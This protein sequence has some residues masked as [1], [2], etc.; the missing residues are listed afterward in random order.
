MTVRLPAEWEP[1]DAVLLAW[2][3]EETDW[4]SVLPLVEPVFLQLAATISRYEQVLIVTTDPVSLS[5]KLATFGATMSAITLVQVA[6]DDTWCRDFGPITVLDDSAPR[7]Q[8]FV[9]NGWGNKFFAEQDNAVTGH[10]QQQNTFS[11]PVDD[12]SLV[13]E[14][15]SIESDGCGTLLTTSQCL[16][17]SNRNPDYSKEQIEGELQDTLGCRR[18]LWLHHGHLLGDDTDAHIDTLA[19]LAPNDTILYV[20]CDDRED[21]H[22]P[23]LSRMAEELAAFRTDAG[24]PYRL[25]PLPWPAALF[26]AEGHR[27]PATYANFLIIN[28][29]V[30]VPTY[31]DPQDDAALAAVSAAF[32]DREII[33]IDCSAIILQHGSLH[34]LTM[35]LPQGVLP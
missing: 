15:G 13:L 10:L 14:G 8:D 24:H 23:A 12:R 31:S 29:A 28:G 4:A 16:L 18:I 3:H 21:E 5:D 32:P 9:F 34:C 33:G 7:L 25:L 2:P 19:R 26:D 6:F 35:Q 17:N 30:L 11:A 27:L 22:Y 20:A 1:Q